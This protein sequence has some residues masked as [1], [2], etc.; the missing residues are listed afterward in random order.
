MDPNKNIAEQLRLAERVL[1]EHD[2][3]ERVVSAS[4]AVALAEHVL[5]L[6]SWLRH[7]GFLPAAWRV[8]WGQEGTND[9]HRG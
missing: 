5:A 4:A 2:L 7:G 3:D 6:D 9:N 1:M 8:S